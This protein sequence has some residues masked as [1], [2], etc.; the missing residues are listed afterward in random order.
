MQILS[1]T[2]AASR[3]SSIP[4]GKRRPTA[5]EPYV[6]VDR[7]PTTPA[8]HPYTAI[9]RGAGSRPTTLYF[10]ELDGFANFFLR[11]P[12]DEAGFGGA[13]FSGVLTDGSS[14]SVRGPWSG[15][16]ALINS[17]PGLASSPLSHIAISDSPPHS[18]IA[19][20]VTIPV[21][22]EIETH[23]APHWR[24]EVPS[25]PPISPRG[26]LADLSDAQ[27]AAVLAGTSDDPALSNP[28]YP[29]FVPTAPFADCATCDGFA[30]ISLGPCSRCDG[31]GID[32]R[33]PQSRCHAHDSVSGGWCSRG[34]LH[35]SCPTCG[36]RHCAAGIAA[37]PHMEFGV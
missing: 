5:F 1:V 20:F 30:T 8:S 9:P 18:W 15:S 36:N 24:L 16:C 23:V 13:V 19:A 35:K 27:S 2:F 37:Y 21:L 12:R 25:S 4:E 3:G 17:I 10:R 28:G 34:T 29:Y 22:R 7:R 31:T 6:V 26:G 14:F 32:P 11:N 33:Y